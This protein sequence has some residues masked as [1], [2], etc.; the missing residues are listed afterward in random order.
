MA[1][2]AP[3]TEAEIMTTTTL[4]VGSE[5]GRLREAIVHRPGL[6]LDRLT[7]G[8]VDELLFDDVL[9]GARA[10][11]EHDHFVEV[12]RGRGVVVHHFGELLAETLAV[13]DGRQFV[14][15]RVC[16]PQRLG[17]VL[18]GE[19]RRLFDDSSPTELAELLI[20][21]V[22]KSDLAPLGTPSLR[23]HTLDIDDFV[24]PPLPNTLFQRDN[25]AWIYG[26]TTINP[27]AKPARQRESIHTRAVYAWHPRFADEHFVTYYGDDD[28]DHQPASLE[29]GDIHVLGNATV[30]VGMGE[31]ST[32][33]AVE[34]L[35]QELF[36]S[37]QAQRVIATTL[38]HSHASMHLDTVLTMVD[39][40][41]FVLY[42]YLDR[43]ALRT[44]LIT[45]SDPEEVLTP[46][47][48]GLVIEQRADL[49]DTIAE[50]LELDKVH[51]LTSDADSRTAEREQW[52]DATNF[53]AVEPGVVIGYDR[54]VA[55]NTMLRRHGIEVLTVGGGELGRGRGG[56]RCMTCPIQRDG[57]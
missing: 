11:E 35:A 52:D 54:N 55:T 22:I 19:V 10:R 33:M 48:A 1:E 23:W 9:W 37:G 28:F 21:G 39:R 20:G 8:N 41:T 49:F 26:G 25:A 13:S 32:S 16:T 45:A 43:A 57:I 30:L 31:R 38:P 4:H 36:S 34:L 47:G 14:L 3:T 44:W 53:L 12:L 15:D 40:D 56:S 42:P 17:P 29:G 18:S 46:S 7:P 50:C 6:E 27:M 5:A 51:V 24:L 2:L